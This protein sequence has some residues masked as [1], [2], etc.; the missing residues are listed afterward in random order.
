MDVNVGMGAVVVRNGPREGVLG[1]CCL[2]L[3]RRRRTRMSYSV[4]GRTGESRRG[5]WPEG[6][7]R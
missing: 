3:R 7:K 6:E 4:T 1:R 2:S 5:S